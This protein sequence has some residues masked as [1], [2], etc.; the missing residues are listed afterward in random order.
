MIG[1]G[2][3]DTN[4]QTITRI[5]ARVSIGHEQLRACIQ[6]VA[7]ALAI[8]Q[9]RF[10]GQTNVD[11]PPPDVLGRI[12]RLD[13][14]FILRAASGLVTATRSLCPRVGNDRI[15]INNRILIQTRSRRVANDVSDGNAA[16][17]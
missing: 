3:N 17:R 4:L 11:V 1:A 15:A 9:E 6:V 7:C 5:P 16:A 13:N 8:D 12:G 2:A 10:L 14:A